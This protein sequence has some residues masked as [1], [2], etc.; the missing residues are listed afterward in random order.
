MD[1]PIATAPGSDTNARF[2]QSVGH[3]RRER[4]SQ[5]ASANGVL[6]APRLRL[7]SQLACMTHR[8]RSGFR[9]SRAAGEVLALIRERKAGLGPAI[10]RF[11]INADDPY[12]TAGV[13]LLISWSPAR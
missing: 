8:Y 5:Q 10:L 11:S 1:D 12:G 9:H 4:V 6:T 13:C 2:R 3:E 7:K